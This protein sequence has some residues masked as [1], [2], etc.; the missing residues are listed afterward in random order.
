MDVH[1]DRDYYWWSGSTRAPHKLPHCAE[2]VSWEG[3]DRSNFL[4]QPFHPHPSMVIRNA[5]LIVPTQLDAPSLWHDNWR[6]STVR[7]AMAQGRGEGDKEKLAYLAPPKKKGPRPL[8][9][10]PLTFS[11]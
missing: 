4:L 5:F 6:L 11:V 1:D 10:S 9:R 7:P 2:V 3:P 8:R